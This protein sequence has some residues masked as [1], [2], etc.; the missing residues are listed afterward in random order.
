MDERK[1]NCSNGCIEFVIKTYTDI[2]MQ[3]KIYTYS[4]KIQEIVF[5]NRIIFF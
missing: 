4:N 2:L 3:N 5:L 1:R